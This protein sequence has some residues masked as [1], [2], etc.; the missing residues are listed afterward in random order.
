MKLLILA[1]C[2]LFSVSLFAKDRACAKDQKKF[3]SKVKGEEKIA[4]CLKKHKKEL[5][6][7]CKAKKAGKTSKEKSKLKKKSK[8]SKHS[9][10]METNFR[11]STQEA[12]QTV[13]PDAV[14]VIIPESALLSPEKI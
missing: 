5:S 8:K 10:F 14:E 13:K 7:A 9:A 3:C 6:K 4:K 2:L 12:K 11:E 1:L